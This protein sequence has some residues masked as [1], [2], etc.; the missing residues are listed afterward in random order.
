M[1]VNKLSNKPRQSSPLSY[2]QSTLP[3]FLQ[4]SQSASQL[5]S[6]TNTVDS[7]SSDLSSPPKDKLNNGVCFNIIIFNFLVYN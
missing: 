5:F 3:T 6:P 2:N 4:N 1:L 7:A